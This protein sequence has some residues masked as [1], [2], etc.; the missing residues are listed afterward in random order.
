MMKNKREFAALAVAVV[1]MVAIAIVF[2]FSESGPTPDIQREQH[3]NA[4]SAAPNET[5][6][7]ADA[8][9]AGDRPVN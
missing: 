5:L 8:G 4:G 6:P 7:P 9:T 3:Q 1:V 2:I